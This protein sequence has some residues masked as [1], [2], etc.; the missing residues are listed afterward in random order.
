MHGRGIVAVSKIAQAEPILG[1]G[2]VSYTNKAG[3]VEALRQGRAV[4]QW[5]DDVFSCEVEGESEDEGPFLVN[6]SCDP[7]AWM[8][9]AYTICAR[10]DISAGEEITAD[11]ALWE[12]DE[13]HVSSRLCHC[14]SPLCRVRIAGA[15]WKNA[16]LR[17]R[18]RGH[19]SPFLTKRIEEEETGVV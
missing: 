9:G 16:S 15:D 13:S 10:R 11:Y 17:E 3:A 14:G 1:W 6:H 12:T 2:G 8:A 19:F 18:Y 7:N 4:M 5:D